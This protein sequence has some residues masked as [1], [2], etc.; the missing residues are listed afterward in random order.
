MP[1]ITG[2]RHADRVRALLDEFDDH[3]ATA[4]RAA[5]ALLLKSID[6]GGIVH[7]A[8]AGHSLAMV[9]ETFYRAG[10]LA[11]VRPLWDLSVLPL[12]GALTSTAAERRPGLGRTVFQKA[13]L[14][15]T[16]VVVVFSTSGCNPYPVEI[17]QEAMASGVPVIAVTSSAA[18]AA[19]AAR[20][21]TKLAEHASIV[22]DTMIP[23]GDVTYPPEAPHT[24]ALSTVLA[25]YVWSHLLA[26]LDD[27]ARAQG[28]EL[29]LW[30]SANVPGGD[31]TNEGLLERYRERIPELA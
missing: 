2:K 28:S 16:D 26:E 11:P 12:A 9:C 1:E 24:A 17:A 10:G 29:P 14:R 4:I 13:E 15:S 19:A 6:A 25:S 18:A 27:L 21:G 31:E 5:A 3:S 7:V 22:I 30:V 8:G 23:A 20:A